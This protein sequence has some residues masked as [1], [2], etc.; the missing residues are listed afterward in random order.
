MDSENNRPNLSKGNEPNVSKRLLYEY[1]EQIILSIEAKT[2]YN[3]TLS[4][5]KSLKCIW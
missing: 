5:M 4:S 1:I 2:T 3:W